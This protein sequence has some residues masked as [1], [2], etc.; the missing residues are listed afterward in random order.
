MG[1]LAIFWQLDD[2]KFRKNEQNSLTMDIPFQRLVS[3]FLLY[4]DMVEITQR[5]NISY[6]L[7]FEG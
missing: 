2:E 1:N 4:V 3:L 5:L 6:Y 7:I